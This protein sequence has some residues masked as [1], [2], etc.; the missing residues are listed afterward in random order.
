MTDINKANKVKLNKKGKDFI[1]LVDSDKALA[2]KQGKITDVKEVLAADFI[3]KN[4]AKAEKASDSDM[5]S[6]FKTK[7]V[8]EVATTILKEGNLEL[9]TSQKN[10]ERDE[11]KKRIIAIIARNAVDPRTGLA[12]P[13]PR[14][15]SAVEEAK[16]N[17]QEGKSAE[18][19]VNDVVSQ[20]TTVLPIKFEKRRLEIVIPSNFAGQSFRVLKSYGNVIKNEYLNDG[21]LKAVV[22]IPA[23]IQDEFFSELNKLCHG[24]VQSK[25]LEK[26]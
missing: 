14:I 26:L 23:G 24:E 20:L 9:T 10:Q 3:F 7:D 5:K 19:Q 21:S 15:E 13:L 2:F 6:V 16:V 22:E 12:H 17:I 25:I 1:I 8:Y 11:L 4:V 18:E